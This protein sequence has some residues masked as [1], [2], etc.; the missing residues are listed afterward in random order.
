M[1]IIFYE[2]LVT[3]LKTSVVMSPEA[4]LSDMYI[5]MDLSPTIYVM[6]NL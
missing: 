3:G 4:G 5:E 6:E 2:M 1:K